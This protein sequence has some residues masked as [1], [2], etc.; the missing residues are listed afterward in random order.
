MKYMIHATVDTIEIRSDSGDLKGKCEVPEF[1]VTAESEGEA[2]ALAKEIVDPL[3]MTDTVIRAVEAPR[4]PWRWNMERELE[5]ALRALAGDSND[6]EH[7]ALLGLGEAVAKYLG[8]D[9]E[10]LMYGKDGE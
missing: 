10:Q 1:V 4:P 6:A 8:R 5:E 2:L 3:Q 9:W 7:E